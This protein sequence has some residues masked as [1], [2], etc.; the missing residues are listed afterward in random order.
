MAA[1]ARSSVACEAVSSGL[2]HLH[3]NA[4]VYRL[5]DQQTG[6]DTACVPQFDPATAII[7]PFKLRGYLLSSTHPLGSHKAAFFRSLGYRAAAPQVLTR[8]LIALLAMHSEAIDATR[9]GRKYA[10]RGQL[11]GPNG[12][13]GLVLAI[14]IILLGETAPRFVT[15]YPGGLNRDVQ[16]T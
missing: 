2:E 4:P 9:Y 16:R 7:S 15:A 1:K 11:Q 6:P 3:S 13:Q 8:D 14:W 12:R 10:S 5:A